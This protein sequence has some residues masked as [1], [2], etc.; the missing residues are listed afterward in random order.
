MEDA[1][2]DP[3]VRRRAEKPVACHR[4]LPPCLPLDAMLLLGLRCLWTARAPGPPPLSSNYVRVRFGAAQ[5]EAIVETSGVE[6]EMNEK[7][8]DLTCH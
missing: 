5:V 2:P 4:G 1:A 6:S 8:L 3:G 7:A